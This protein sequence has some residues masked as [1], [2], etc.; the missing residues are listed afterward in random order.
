ML[1][2]GIGHGVAALEG[3]VAEEVTEPVAG[4]QLRK[5]LPSVEHGGRSIGQ[6]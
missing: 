1:G 5:S 4:Q 6:G 3:V 2:E